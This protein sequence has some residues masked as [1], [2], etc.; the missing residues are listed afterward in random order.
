[1]R[2]GNKPFCNGPEEDEPDEDEAEEEEVPTPLAAAGAGVAPLVDDELV[3]DRGGGLASVVGGKGVVVVEAE[4][5]GIGN[6]VFGSIVV[7][8]DASIATA[9]G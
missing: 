2:T 4:V 7:M 9:M 8:R 1:M 5:E 3:R 6:K